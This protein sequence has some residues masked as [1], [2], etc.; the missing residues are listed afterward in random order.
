MRHESRTYA[1]CYSG[2]KITCESKVR[3]KFDYNIRRAKGPGPKVSTVSVSNRYV[4]DGHVA[5]PIS[6]QISEQGPEEPNQAEQAKPESV[7]ETSDIE[8]R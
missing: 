5:S 1:S 3:F 4:V 7:H 2:L 6:E 8:V